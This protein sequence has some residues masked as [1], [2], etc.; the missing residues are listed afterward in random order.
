MEL[1]LLWTD[2]ASLGRRAWQGARARRS[3]RL[4]QDLAEHYRGRDAE[5]G[6]RLANQCYRRA[7][8]KL[9]LPA[10]VRGSR[11]LAAVVSDRL[12][13]TTIRAAIGRNRRPVLI[14]AAAT[15]TLAGLVVGL[16]PPARHAVFPVDLAHGRPWVATS[17]WGSGFTTSGVMGEAP[18]LEGFF[19][20]NEEQSPSLTIDL[21]AIKK[22]RAVEIE[23]RHDQLRERALPLAVEVSA[24]RHTW[25][26]VGYRRVAFDKWTAKFPR[27][28]VR[29]VRAR[30]DRVSYLHLHGI[31]VF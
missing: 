11:P 25:M 6:E 28:P 31:R 19:H 26:R 5:R 10:D 23:N 22:V 2:F 20:T 18:K 27:M 24:D 15:V 7:L 21:G 8:R 3:Y 14:G 1:R 17:A 13:E 30:V 12:A 29:Y 4:G 9:N 16:V